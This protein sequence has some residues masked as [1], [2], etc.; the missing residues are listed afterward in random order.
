MYLLGLPADAG[1]QRVALVTRLFPSARLTPLGS[2]RAPVVAAARLRASTPHRP[3]R[4]VDPVAVVRSILASLTLARG[5][6]QLVLQLLLGPRRV[7]LA[8]P[9]QSPSSIVAPWWQV[10]WRGNGGQVD[11]EK[12]SALR[13]KVGDHGFA[14]SLR[15]GVTAAT[16][17][18][19]RSLLLGVLA[20]VRTSEGPGVQLRLAGEPPMRLNEARTPWRWPLRL[21]VQE[22]TG[23]TA[24]PLGDV[25]LPGQPA[26]H[27][28]A[29]APAPGTTGDQ[30]VIAAALAPGSEAKLVVRPADALHHTHVIGPT[31]S[32]KSV[33]LGRLIAQDIANGRGVIVVEPKGDLVDDVL[34]HVSKHRRPDVGV[35]DASDDA[36]V[37]LNPLMARGRRPEVIADSLL[38][39]FRHLY[40][41]AIGPR[42]GDILYAATLTLAQRPGASLVMVPQL[43]TN[44]GF[45]RS[46]T[47]DIHDPIALEP[48]W[49]GYEAWSDAERSQAI[50]PLMN[51]LRPFLL[52]PGL[53]AVLG[54]QHPRFSLQE[55]FE[56]RKILLVPLRRGL[57]GTEAAALLGSLVVS[58]VW[59]ATQER[60]GIAPS[61]RHPVMVYIDEVQ[62]FLALPTD[63]GDAL[64]QARG[65]G[66]AFHLAH[67]YLSQMSVPMQRA[68]LANAR[69]R[70]VFQ[71]GHADAVEFAKAHPEIVA[72]DLTALGQY[73]V[74]AS[75]FARG[76]VNPY[77]LGKT[78]PPEKPLSD[79]AS[80]RRISRERYGRP[81]AEVEAEWA[82]FTPD[83]RRS[84]RSHPTE[85]QRASDHQSNIDPGTGE[86]GESTGGDDLGRRPRGR[87]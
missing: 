62:D 2:E 44:P 26:L 36:P 82:S 12:R 11:G 70:V 50:A 46:L 25:D 31:G 24:W 59:Q 43:L 83:P 76:R 47:R 15:I 63:L 58:E 74:Y 71:T 54:Q 33:M 57:L 39:I 3:L 67:Q 34:A 75:L 20:A 5:E 1:R 56:Q 73:Q 8:I 65:Y 87:R 45:R 77:A 42:S 64:A 72:D 52:R 14:C 61:E 19:R 30:R 48:F 49:A 6:E 80:L 18:R 51:K 86:P 55:V 60:A 7:P 21:N 40:G 53:R 78:L 81:V 17:T 9:N 66:V 29:L 4:T 13:A 84:A 38:A 16:K 32:G 79:P 35:L 37:G 41:D 68:I 23:L 22:L 28:S 85:K 10:A 69:S 27:P